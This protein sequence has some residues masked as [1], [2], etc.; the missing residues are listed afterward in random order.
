MI[1]MSGPCVIESYENLSKIAQMLKPLAN[2]PKI[3]FYFKSSFDKANRTSLDSYRGPGLEEGIEILKSIKKEFGYKIIT[4]IHESTQTSKI[5]EVADVIQIPAFLCRQTDLI[6]SVAK[7]DKIINIKKGQ[8]MNPIDMQYSVLKAIKTRGG[9]KASYEESQ[10]YK[11]WLTERG[12]SFGYGNLVVDMRGLKIMREFAPVIF[13]AT[14]SVQMPGAGGGKSGGDS[15]FVPLLSRSAAAAGVD[16][17]F[18][19]T[20]FDPSIALSDG[21]NMIET[22]KLEALINQLLA[23]SEI[24]Q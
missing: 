4:D 23:I 2:H 12:S 19:E 20:H 11:V 15:S 7:T 1:L 21:P 9:E 17:F 6:V 24:S 18:M 16:G 13:D 8:F 14:H 22:Q 10:K 3:D 5:A